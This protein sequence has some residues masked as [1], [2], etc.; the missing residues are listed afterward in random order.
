MLITGGSRGIGAATALLAAEAGYADQAHMGRE[1]RRITGM[2]PAKI[3][4]LI[5]TEESYWPYRLLG[6]RYR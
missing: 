2:P 4:N 3:V 5:A 6:E 1:V